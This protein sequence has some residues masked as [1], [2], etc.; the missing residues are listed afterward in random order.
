MLIF[1]MGGIPLV[2]GKDHLRA[3][4]FPILLLFF[5]DSEFHF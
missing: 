4:L 1:I 2:F 3:P 5:H